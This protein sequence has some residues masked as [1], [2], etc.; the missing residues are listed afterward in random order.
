MSTATRSQAKMTE[1]PYSDAKSRKE[2]GFE[3]RKV[4]TR[5]TLESLTLGSSNA[6]QTLAGRQTW[7]DKRWGLECL[8]D[9]K[10]EKTM[11]TEE[12]SDKVTGFAFWASTVVI[13]NSVLTLN[14][15]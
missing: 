1:K 15:V 4:E 10:P 13:A 12:S 3:W 2:H 9:V 14:E 6:A 5:A 11:D 7:R 8:S